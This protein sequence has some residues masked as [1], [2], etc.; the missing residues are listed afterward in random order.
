MAFDIRKFGRLE[1]NIFDG[2]VT[3]VLLDGFTSGDYVGSAL[4]TANRRSFEEAFEGRDWWTDKALGHGA[5]GIYVALNVADVATEEDLETLQ[6]M[7]KGLK[8][9]PVLDEEILSQVEQ[10]IVDENWVEW[11]ARD[12]Q[13]MLSKI[14]AEVGFD[15]ETTE[16]IEELD[17]NQL[18]RLYA[19]LADARGYGPENESATSARFDFERVLEPLTVAPGYAEEDPPDLEPLGDAVL[20][21]V[22]NTT[23]AKDVDYDKLISLS[24][25]LFSYARRNASDRAVFNDKLLEAGDLKARG[26]LFMSKGG[27]TG[28]G[29]VRGYPLAGSIKNVS[30]TGRAKKSRR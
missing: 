10:E 15:D 3:G 12:F 5:V 6:E 14:Y 4:E 20:S 9:Y 13:E 21:T 28:Y 30:V 25:A 19:A 29:D 23:A 18:M 8:D 27:K 11:A 16:R 7:L 26:A 1:A 24:S 22:L 17:R 2:G